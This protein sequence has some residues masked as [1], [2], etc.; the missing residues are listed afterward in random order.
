MENA[1]EDFPNFVYG[2]CNIINLER[3][4]LKNIHPEAFNKAYAVHEIS[5]AFN[6]LEHLHSSLFQNSFFVIEMNL[7]HN[8]LRYLDD[9]FLTNF[10]ML[11]KLNL[12]NNR[13]ESLSGEYLYSSMLKELSINNNKIKIFEIGFMIRMGRIYTPTIKISFENTTCYANNKSWV[14]APTY[15][16]NKPWVK[17]LLP[18]IECNRTQ[19]ESG[20]N[21]K[22]EQSTV[23]RRCNIYIIYNYRVV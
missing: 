20:F 3:R 13:I 18:T 8:K 16:N 17:S 19:L 2:R 7:S 23:Q 11:E 14:I 12:D 22:I 15:E 5:L 4:N 1:T 6:E 21:K 10:L 9:G